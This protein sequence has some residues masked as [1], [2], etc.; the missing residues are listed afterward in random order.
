MKH[1]RAVDDS[2]SISG[3]DSPAVPPTKEAWARAYL[4]STNLAYKIAPPALPPVWTEDYAAEDLRPGRPPELIVSPKKQKSITLGA[5]QRL[6]ARAELH[7]RFWH[8]EL[9]AAELMCWAALK[10]KETP[11][12]F[13]DGLL[14]ICRDEIR[15]MALYQQYIESLGF[16]LRDFA[17]RD[18]FWA[19]IPSCETPLQFVALL[20]I[21]LEGANLDHTARFAS[22]LGAVGDHRGAD[23]QKR[24]GR[25]EVAHV[26]FASRW[27]QI[28]SGGTDFDCWR[29]ELPAPLS[30]LLMRGKTISKGLRLKAELTQDFIDRLE[31]WAPDEEQGGE[32][33]MMQSAAE[34]G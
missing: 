19:R 14:R 4:L 22:W 28:W 11:D 16:E 5:L 27:F 1:K 13:R 6:E 20:G 33:R 15:H 2:D 24:V 9:Q 26:R 21:G 32:G 31:K 17:V 30:P 18:W 34:A 8:H 10:F 12:E 3:R 25:E 7:H 29:A 23:L